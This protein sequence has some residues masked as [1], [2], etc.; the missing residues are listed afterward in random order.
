VKT[1][2]IENNRYR[3]CIAKYDYSPWC[4]EIEFGI[5]GPPRGK[6]YFQSVTIPK[7]TTP[8]KWLLGLAEKGEARDAQDRSVERYCNFLK[9]DNYSNHSPEL[10]LSYYGFTWKQVKEAILKEL[11]PDDNPMPEL[12]KGDVVALHCCRYPEVIQ[13]SGMVPGGVDEVI[14]I[15]RQQP[16]GSLKEIWRRK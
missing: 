12:K 4:L 1:I 3:F 16:D 5:Y 11:K 6:I 10:P 2:K 8:E 15:N 13:V 7:D 9:F 14:T